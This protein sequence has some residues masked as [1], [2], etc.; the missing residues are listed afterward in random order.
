MWPQS[1]DERDILYWIQHE[2]LATYKAQ[3][4]NIVAPPDFALLT[5][6]GSGL[7]TRDSRPDK[8]PSLEARAPSRRRRWK[9]GASYISR[10]P[11]IALD[12]VNSSV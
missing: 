2:E 4:I 7:E 3:G 9:A 6:Y 12:I 5:V 8:P 11:S 1:F 10:R